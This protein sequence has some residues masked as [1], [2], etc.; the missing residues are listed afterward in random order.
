V[1]TAAT[2]SAGA[3]M[4]LSGNAAVAIEAEEEIGVVG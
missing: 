2:Q 4:W 3:P 1:S